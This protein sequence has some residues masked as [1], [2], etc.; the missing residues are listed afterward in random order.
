MQQIEE[1][2]ANPA[3]TIVGP[4]DDLYFGWIRGIPFESHDPDLFFMIKNYLDED[5]VYFD[6]GANIG[7]TVVPVAKY[8][9][10]GSAYAFEPTCAYKYIEKNIE[11][12]SIT[13]LKAYNIA[14]G[15]Q[16]GEVVFKTADC[17][18]HSHCITNS[19]F[20]AEDN[21]DKVRV[22]R[23]DDVVKKENINKIDFIKIDVEGYENNVLEGCGDL[24]T[25]FNPIFYVEFNSWCLMTIQNE[26]PCLFLQYLF[27]K[28]TH[29]YQIR[30][31]T[32]MPLDSEKKLR[33][34]LFE[35]LTKNGCVDNI[36]CLNGEIES[37]KKSKFIFNVHE[38][39]TKIGEKRGDLL[40]SNK[41]QC[42]TLNFGPYVS[43]TKGR[44]KVSISLCVS[45]AR[46]N[47]AVG[48]WDVYTPTFDK[49]I[50]S[51]RISVKNGS[52]IEA[53]FEVMDQMNNAIF[54]IRTFSN[55]KAILELKLIEIK[56]IQ[57]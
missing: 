50:A 21:F 45:A 20:L 17:L 16:Q 1:Q 43:L 14:L 49:Q 11:N 22:E 5:S 42:G 3:V 31:C 26:S 48:S 2:V 53:D 4:E 7:A 56:K 27:K 23:L 52:C 25:K 28:F 39:Q 55:G 9:K 12:N 33:D 34:F 18:A 24:V 40:C 38:L 54:E 15:E 41:G 36:V 30:N 47:D 10:Y 57:N 37:R 8:L 19:N 51:G 46:K 32:L 13:N 44:Y 29:L 6:V 35:N